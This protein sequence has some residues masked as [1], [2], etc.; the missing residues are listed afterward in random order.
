M[1]HK[2]WSVAAGAAA[3]SIGSVAQAAPVISYFYQP[4]GDFTAYFGDSPKTTSFN[5]FFTPFTITNFRGGQ[6][7]ATLST[8]GV[9][10]KTDLDFSTAEFLGPNGLI[11][12]FTLIKLPLT[13]GSTTNPDGLEYGLV[14]DVSI[15]PGTYQLHITGTAFGPGGVTPLSG[16]FSYF[17]TPAPEPSTWA[18]MITGFG[19]IGFA[20]RRQ[21]AVVAARRLSGFAYA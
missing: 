14:S 18:M 15:A 10:P 1:A 16:Q 20:M 19:L 5:D 12:P 7:T 8:S 6:L 4:N 9:F 3:L 21:R 2:L 13:F 17:A 11:I